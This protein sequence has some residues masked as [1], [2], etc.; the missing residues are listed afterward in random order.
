MEMWKNQGRTAPAT[1]IQGL[2]GYDWRHWCSSGRSRNPQ[3]GPCT[4]LDPFWRAA[5]L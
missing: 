3:A 4:L 2:E 5:R 1:L